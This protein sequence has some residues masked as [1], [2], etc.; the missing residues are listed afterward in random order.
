MGYC[1]GNCDKLNSRYHKCDRYNKRLTC[2]KQS[3]RGS[4]GFCVHEQCSECQKDEYIETQEKRIRKLIEINEY[5]KNQSI[6]DKAKLDEIR[7]YMAQN[8]ID[9]DEVI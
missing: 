5:W 4:I 6:S 8:G 3:E 2:M 9:M 1:N 7:I